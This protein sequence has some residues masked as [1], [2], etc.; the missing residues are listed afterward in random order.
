MVLA[1]D[2]R[3]VRDALAMVPEEQRRAIDLA[4]FGGYTHRETAGM[5]GAPLGTVKGRIR[6]GIE[7]LRSLLKHQG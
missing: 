5:T 6:I 7:K 1:V 4:Y 3:A 2:A